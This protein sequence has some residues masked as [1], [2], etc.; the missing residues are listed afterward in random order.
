[1]GCGCATEGLNPGEDQLYTLDSGLKLKPAITEITVKCLMKGYLIR[2]V[3]QKPK[4]PNLADQQ[5]HVS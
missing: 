4:D 3:A 5:D 2:K 1:M